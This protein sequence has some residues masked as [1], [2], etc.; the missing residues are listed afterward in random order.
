[1][2][3]TCKKSISPWHL[4]IWDEWQ[5]THIDRQ[6]WFSRRLL[7]LLF[8]Q[9]LPPTNVTKDEGSREQQ[10]D[11]I[12]RNTL[13]LS[14]STKHWARWEEKGLILCKT[15]AFVLHCSQLP[16]VKWNICTKINVKRPGRLYKAQYAMNEPLWLCALGVL[17]EKQTNKQNRPPES[18][19]TCAFKPQ[20]EN[21]S[22]KLFK[23]SPHPHIPQ[24]L[25]HYFYL[26]GL[27]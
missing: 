12:W 9:Q 3:L 5:A 17:N 25:F 14:Y 2:H 6:P 22:R 7:L 13:A 26:L 16:Q 24:H 19:C 27:I 21:S 18:S 11:D 23:T 20:F 15:R 1:M 10:S 8:C 4:K